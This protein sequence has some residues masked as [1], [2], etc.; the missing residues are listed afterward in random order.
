MP[1]PVARRRM[2]EWHSC[3]SGGILICSMCGVM[4]GSN[5]PL[6]LQ[7]HCPWVLAETKGKHPN[8]RE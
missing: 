6:N 8:T 7:S 1:S 3:K 2:P 4:A 5:Y